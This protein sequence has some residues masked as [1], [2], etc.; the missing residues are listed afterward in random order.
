[1]T[2]D[3]EPTL[4]D[5]YMQESW[6]ARAKRKPGRPKGLPKTGGRKKGTPNRTRVQI[7]ERIN[8]KADPIGFLILVSR[9]LQFEAATEA[10]AATKKKMYPT[11]DQRIDAAKILARKVLPDLKSTEL[12][13]DL[14]PPIARIE[15]VIIEPGADAPDVAKAVG[16]GAAET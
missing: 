15:R 3:M 11:P 1:M 14:G 6:E 10:G 8:E 2:D 13:G 9:G 5:E 4:V 16:N 12:T 7:L